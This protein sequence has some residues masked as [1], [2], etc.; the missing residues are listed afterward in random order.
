MRMLPP[1][2]ILQQ[3]HRKVLVCLQARPAF[4]F[5]FSVL[6]YIDRFSFVLVKPRFSDW[7]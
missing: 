4:E 5:T 6:D 7:I 3:V 2:T 1:G